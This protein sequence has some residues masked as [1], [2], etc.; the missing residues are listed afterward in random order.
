[1]IRDLFM[2][3]KRSIL[4]D[5]LIVMGLL[6][7]LERTFRMYLSLTSRMVM[8]T[9]G[10]GL[11]M[12]LPS[13]T[14]HAQSATTITRPEVGWMPPSARGI[15]SS[16]YNL[17]EALGLPTCGHAQV[18]KVTQ[19]GFVCVHAATETARGVSCGSAQG[20]HSNGSALTCTSIR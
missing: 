2:T 4:I 17:A 18:L 14:A 7:G 6:S 1:M 9:L 11:A 10:L 8:A 13:P 15:D 12:A 19:E 3:F 5:L 16:Q 20:L